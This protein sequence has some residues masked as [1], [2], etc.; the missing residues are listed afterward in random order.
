MVRRASDRAPHGGCM[1]FV[2]PDLAS[3]VFWIAL[4][5]IIVANLILSGD[6]AVVI[7]MACR[8]LPEKFKRPAIIGG[9]AGAILLRV[10]FVFLI[11]WLLSIPYVK[12][13]GGLLLLWIGI[14]LL[15][16]D[17]GHGDGLQ[18]STNIWSAVWTIIVADAVMSLDNAIAIAGAARGDGVLIML[19]LLI[20]MPIIIVGSTLLTTILQRYPILV[21]L[22]GA[23]LGFLGGEIMAADGKSD[24][25]DAAGRKSVVVKPGSIAEF[26]DARIPHAELVCGVVGAV[27]VVAIGMWLSRR[28]KPAEEAVDLA[29]H[30]ASDDPA[31][32]S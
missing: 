16:E 3:A 19:G 4:G 1:I 20:S 2:M 25:F 13:I 15:N 11:G 17:E 10:I 8:N 31:K 12:L 27:I 29:E 18:A 32:K 26:L 6:N 14:K 24:V 9:S 5:K 21:I 28:R 23:L 22:G 7:A 30:N